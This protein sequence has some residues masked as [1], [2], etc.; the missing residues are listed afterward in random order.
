[1]I[2]N[3]QYIINFILIVGLIFCITDIRNLTKKINKIE[4]MKEGK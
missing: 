1:M 2:T 4:K 3:I